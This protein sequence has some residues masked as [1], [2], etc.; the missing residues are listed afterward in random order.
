MFGST[1][2][3]FR[4]QLKTN[5]KEIKKHYKICIKTK[6]LIIKTTIS[7]MFSFKLS[8]MQ[9]L[10]C[11]ENAGPV[12]LLLTFNLELVFSDDA[13][14]FFNN[15]WSV[16]NISKMLMLLQ[17]YITIFQRMSPRI[18]ISKW[19]LQTQSMSAMK[20]KGNEKQLG[21]F[22]RTQKKQQ[23]FCSDYVIMTIKI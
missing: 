2:P 17:F 6:S 14:L 5:N 12:I 8:F 3:F 20:K 13:F 19:T 7:I 9:H 21:F 4:T 15:S 23:F 10:F 16:Y 18:S 1:R 11:N 22:L